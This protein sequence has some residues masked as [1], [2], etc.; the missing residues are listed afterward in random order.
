MQWQLTLPIDCRKEKYK[1]AKP[2]SRKLFLKRTNSSKFCQQET[3]RGVSSSYHE[4][5]TV[6]PRTS[7][8][9]DDFANVC[10]DSKA[11]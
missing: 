1:K 5:L 3:T 2:S 8:L 4:I 7:E 6:L 11:P 9:A 10:K